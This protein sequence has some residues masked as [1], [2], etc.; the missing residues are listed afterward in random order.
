MAC[1]VLLLRLG[2]PL[3][4]IGFNLTLGGDM[5][6]IISVSSE[7]KVFIVCTLSTG[8]ISKLIQ[9]ANEV[10]SG[11]DLFP[12][13]SWSSICGLPLAVAVDRAELVPVHDVTELWPIY[14]L[15]AVTLTTWL[16]GLSD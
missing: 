15:R 8:T 3:S 16:L 7:F 12:I 6:H 9:G 13:D 1:C 14:R 10:H 2:L 5:L 4:P 11:L